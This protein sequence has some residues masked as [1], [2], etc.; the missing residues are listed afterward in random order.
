MKFSNSEPLCLGF[1]SHF[2]LG[3]EKVRQDYWLKSLQNLL[4]GN[5]NTEMQ[6]LS[7]DY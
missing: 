1:W 5:L 2:R 7:H 4:N 6:G 3:L